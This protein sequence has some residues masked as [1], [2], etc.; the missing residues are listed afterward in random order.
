MYD[1]RLLNND[2][3]M[4]S[5]RDRSQAISLE[6]AAKSNEKRKM[7]VE[8]HY[9]TTQ[10]RNKYNE[11]TANLK[12]V[13]VTEALY[14][15]VE[16][17]LPKNTPS[18]LLKYGKNAIYS[19]VTTEDANKLVTR[20][21][22]K[23][24]F[25]SELANIVEASEYEI[26][27]KCDANNDATFCIKNSDFDKFRDKVSKLDIEDVSKTI[28]DRVAAAENDFVKANLKDKE[29]LE[30]IAQ[31]TKEKIDSVRSDD[32]QD[33]ENIKQELAITYRRNVSDNIINRKKNILEALV[34]RM[35]KK[36]LI[37]ES[38]NEDFLMNESSKLNT[39]K[40]IELS[41]VLYTVLEMVNTCKVLPVDS[42]Y[43]SEV[44]NSI[45]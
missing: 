14:M 1:S 37:N 8:N 6:R 23:T 26:V 12:N 31:K 30:N 39:N 9:R 28:A 16:N 25:L 41:E 20:F 22:T 27:K 2:N 17:A 42:K 21:H 35:S 11:F 44:L 13:L 43:I 18:E 34:T 3:L 32:E 38:S 33:E 7:L 5:A 4:L 19:I 40:V 15:I 45:E 10:N 24:A 36:I 29:D